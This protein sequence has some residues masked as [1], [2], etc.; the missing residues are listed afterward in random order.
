MG[1]AC[2]LDQVLPICWLLAS[3][4]FPLQPSVNK[5]MDCVLPWDWMPAPLESPCLLQMAQARKEDLGGAEGFPL[6]G[7][8]QVSV[9]LLVEAGGRETLWLECAQG[10]PVVAML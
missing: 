2:P 5:R 9:C 10:W 4:C 7:V 8:M 1:C 3:V 6:T